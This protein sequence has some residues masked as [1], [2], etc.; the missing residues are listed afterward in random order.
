MQWRSFIRTERV[1][2]MRFFNYKNLLKWPDTLHWQ[3][4]AHCA[5]WVTVFLFS[6]LLFQCNLQVVRNAC[7]CLNLW[8]IKILPNLKEFYSLQK[9]E[10]K[11]I[12]IF[13]KWIM[14][15]IHHNENRNHLQFVCRF[16]PHDIMKHSNYVIGTRLEIQN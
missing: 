6:K 13:L 14:I 11:T 15:S 12:N 16:L 3:I 8:Q 2:Q 10:R 9:R 4:D 5:L 7:V 1:P